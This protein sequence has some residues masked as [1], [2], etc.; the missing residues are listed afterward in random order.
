MP[1]KELNFLS[2]P[3]TWSTIEHVSQHINF[4]QF[5]NP[6][7]GTYSSTWNYFQ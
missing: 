1:S 7:R 3:G 6:I 2:I 5:F 4:I